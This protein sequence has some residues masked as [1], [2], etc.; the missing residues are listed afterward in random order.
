MKYIN[1]YFN[2]ED[3][4]QLKNLAYLALIIN[5]VVEVLNKDAF[6]NTIKRIFLQPHIMIYNSLIISVTLSITLLV[7]RRILVAFIISSLWVAFGITN[8]VLLIFRTTP[9]TAVDLTLI[10]E[11]I[12]MIKRYLNPLVIILIILGF[13]ALIVAIIYAFMKAPTYKGKISYVKNFIIITFILGITVFT[14]QI[15]VKANLLG[16]NFGNIGYAFKDYGFAYCFVNS[17]INTG[18]H[19]PDNYSEEVI[20]DII[21]DSILDETDDYTDIQKP[22]DVDNQKEPIETVK[23]EITTITRNIIFLQLE[24]FFDPTHINGFTFSSD[25]TPYYRLLKENFSSGYLNVPSIGAGTANTEFEIITGMS[26]DFFGPG[27]YPYKTIL[28][29]TTSES[30]AFNLASLGYKTHAIHNNNATFYGR[31]I[32]FPNLGF[33]T[34]TSL[35]YMEQELYNPTGWAKDVILI[36]EILKCLDSTEE[37]DY[38]YAISV[39][40]HGKYPSSIDSI[41]DT[42]A[43]GTSDFSVDAILEGSQSIIDSGKEEDNF[44]DI[45]PRDPKSMAA[46]SQSL[47][48]SYTNDWITI[49]GI[50]ENRR[51]AF[52]YYVSQIKEMDQFL[53]QLTSALENYGED[54]VLVLYGDH[55]PSLEIEETDLTN[56]S[57]YQTE[58]V[59]WDNFGLTETPQY[60]DLEA[61]QLYAYVLELFGI[62]N[63]IITKY[64][65]SNQYTLN[66]EYLDKL[67][68]LQY[69][70][71]YGDQEVFQNT[72]PYETVP[73][74]MGAEPLI[75]NHV[76]TDSN[77]FTISGENFTAYSQVELDGNLL[78]TV[79][80]DNETLQVLDVEYISQGSLYVVQI[81][82]D[83][84]ELSRSEAYVLP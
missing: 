42:Q 7:K 34:F 36:N 12:P 70:M 35:E 15:G 56:G 20:Q 73:M 45:P 78:P 6:L 62:T 46:G 32:V 51:F 44:D 49:E 64:H 79:F 22:I 24:S 43:L 58:Y 11:A 4:I 14:T 68:L 81:D 17:V 66:E 61:Y 53:F 23:D 10:S 31:N 84:V 80:L 83:G 82:A 9:F 74:T 39:Q 27:E 16:V 3:Y 19:K 28:K 5:L 29:E 8:Y 57:M 50:E 41:D 76:T 13:V 59:I 25:P 75:I 54:V 71:L 52:E 65:Q 21:N 69:D 26:L 72:N 77:V 63:G 48:E 2:K 60:K 30:V 67:R 40:G 55:L 18:I 1:R 47:I 38:V 33:E 37:Q